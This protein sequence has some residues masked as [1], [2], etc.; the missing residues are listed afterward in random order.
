MKV[1]KSFRL[2]TTTLER[3]EELRLMLDLENNTEVIEKAI[4][5]YMLYAKTFTND[6]TGEE[7]RH[8]FEMVTN[9]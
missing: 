9:D 3:I 7:V 1:T 2:K 4:R 5:F 6:T 8:L